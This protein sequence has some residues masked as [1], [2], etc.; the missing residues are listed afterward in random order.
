MVQRRKNIRHE[1]KK[2]QAENSVSL[3]Q[4]TVSETRTKYYK[5]NNTLIIPSH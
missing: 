1:Q 3:G 4:G 2:V 5:S